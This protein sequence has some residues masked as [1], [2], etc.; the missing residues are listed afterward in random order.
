MDQSS[1]APSAPSSSGV[2]SAAARLLGAGNGS[3]AL[4]F[5]CGNGLNRA[6]SGGSKIGVSVGT[7]IGSSCSQPMVNYDEGTYLIFNSANTLFIRDLNSQD[8]VCVLFTRFNSFISSNFV[9]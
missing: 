8:K 2:R 6:P 5:I 9:V 4:S 3:R 1:A 7:S